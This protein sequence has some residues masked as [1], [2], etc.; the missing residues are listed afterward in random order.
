GIDRGGILRGFVKYMQNRKIEGGSTITQQVVKNAL[1]GSEVSLD[2]KIKEMI[3]AVRL[4]KELQNKDKILEIYFNLIY[5]GRNSWG[6][7]MASRNYFGPDQ[8]VSELDL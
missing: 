5:L 7:G 8:N 3:L 4:E 1:V 2:R 6:V